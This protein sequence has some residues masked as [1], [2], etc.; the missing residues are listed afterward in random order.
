MLGIATCYRASEGVSDRSNERLIDS[1]CSQGDRAKA[2]GRETPHPRHHGFRRR[3]SGDA[4]FLGVERF[5]MSF[6]EEQ[7]M[8]SE[9]R[10]TK[11]NS[12][13]PESPARSAATAAKLRSVGLAGEMALQSL[14][15][16]PG[17]QSIQQGLVRLVGQRDLPRTAA[18]RPT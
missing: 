6:V 10:L 11:D 2:R 3:I 16:H 12:S 5:F 7:E 17:T 18:S 4:T 8:T 14:F 13:L 15:G 1:T 9:A